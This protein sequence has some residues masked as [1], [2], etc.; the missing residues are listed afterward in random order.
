MDGWMD[1]YFFLKES[2][3]WVGRDVPAPAS[4]VGSCL[5]WERNLEVGLGR[6]RKQMAASTAKLRTSLLLFEWVGGWV[7]WMGYWTAGTEKRRVE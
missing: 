1:V 5:A 4:L 3:G 6:Q 2:N 7:V